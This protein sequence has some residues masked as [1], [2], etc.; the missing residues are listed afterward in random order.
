MQYPSDAETQVIYR[1]KLSLLAT[2]AS[3]AAAGNSLGALLVAAMVWPHIHAAL[4]G[5]WV[6]LVMLIVTTRWLH[7]RRYLKAEEPGSLAACF[8]YCATSVAVNGLVWGGLFSYLA[9]SL[10]ATSLAPPFS[11]VCALAA[12]TSLTY[13]AY[14]NPFKNFSVPALLMPGIVLLAS[15]PDEKLWIAIIVLAWFTLM[16]SI[17]SQL[18]RYLESTAKYETENVA[19]IRDLEY[20]REHS[21]RLNEE[22][23]LKTEIIER[24]ARRQQT[25]SESKQRAAG[26]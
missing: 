23:Q 24:L 9:Y 22:L 13:N 4:L 10:E 19:L 25:D 18:S 17:S 8:R 15:G 5:S 26:E 11:V 3:T 20:Q 2:Q 16:Y 1:R 6:G 21:E 14:F 7:V 12:G